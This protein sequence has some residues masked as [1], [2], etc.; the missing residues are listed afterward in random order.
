MDRSPQYGLL[1]RAK[2]DQYRLPCRNWS[3]FDW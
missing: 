3:I 2:N 1:R